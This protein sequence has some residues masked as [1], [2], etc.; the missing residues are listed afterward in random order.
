[1][2]RRMSTVGRDSR[3]GAL[4]K[5][6]IFITV[7]TD[8]HPFDRVVGWVEAWLSSS[9][10]DKARCL[11]QY[12]TSKP[13]LLAEGRDYLRHDQMQATIREATAVVCHGGPSTIMEMRYRGLVPIV[14]PRRSDLGEHVDDHQV[15]FAKRLAGLGDIRIATSPEELGQLLNLAIAEPGR[16]CFTG[17]QPEVAESARRF[18]EMVDHLM[19]SPRRTRVAGLIGGP[20]AFPPELSAGSLATEQ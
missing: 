17:A 6:L 7:G 1:M 19:R 5:P 20:R 14:V 8:H 15:A 10:D 11:I 4:S 2:R 13:P 9:G 18:E 3:G 12:G 16:F